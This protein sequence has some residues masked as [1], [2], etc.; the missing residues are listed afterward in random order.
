[1]QQRDAFLEVIYEKACRERDIILMSADFGAPMIDKFKETIPDQFIHCGISEQN[2][3]NVAV[4][5]AMKSSNGAARK[6]TGAARQ[7]KRRASGRAS[8][9]RHLRTHAPRDSEHQPSLLQLLDWAQSASLPTTQR[10]PRKVHEPAMRQNKL[11]RQLSAV[12]VQSSCRATQKPF[13]HALPRLQSPSEPAT[14]RPARAVQRPKSS[15]AAEFSQSALLPAMQ[16]LP[17]GV[18]RPRLRQSE[19]SPQEATCTTA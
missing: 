14:H 2:M 18:H 9:L 16:V 17:E 15:Q 4:G 5:L 7:R 11:P 1:M 12:A 13:S 6:L 10:P 19:S 3:V 8:T